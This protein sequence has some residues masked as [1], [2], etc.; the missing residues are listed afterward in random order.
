MGSHLSM[1]GHG[2]SSPSASAQRYGYQYAFTL[3][4]CAQVSAA[5]HFP[6]MKTMIP[7]TNAPFRLLRHTCCLLGAAILALSGLNGQVVTTTFESI[8]IGPDA[9]NRDAASQFFSF[10]SDTGILSPVEDRPSFNAL[11]F[12]VVYFD[13]GGYYY[14][15]AQASG[16]MGQNGGFSYAVS[17]VSL[18]AGTTVGAGLTWASPAYFTPGEVNLINVVRGVR[19]DAGEGDFYYG[20]VTLSTGADR[21]GKGPGSMTIISASFE[22]TL[23]SPITVGA[24]IPEPASAALLASLAAAGVMI[25]LRRRRVGTN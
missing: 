24:A 22:T 5:R 20:Y 19:V 11:S 23:N 10:S 12:A 6:S 25:A 3:D 1:R 16:Q 7:T 8:V 21:S 18:T 4:R 13:S 2:V 14:T 9:A 17:D 15:Q